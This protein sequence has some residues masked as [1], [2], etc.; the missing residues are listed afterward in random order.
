[1]A[2]RRRKSSDAPDAAAG[3]WPGVGGEETARVERPA[4]PGR[5]IDRG[6]VPAPA[7]PN[8]GP[9]TLPASGAE[10]QE[11]EEEEISWFG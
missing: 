3:P 1:M 5:L 9:Q 4:R 2:G 10:L 7:V 8:P 11:E 6:G